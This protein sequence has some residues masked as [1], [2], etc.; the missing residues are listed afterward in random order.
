[1]GRASFFCMPG[2]GHVNPTLPL[3]SELVKRGERIDYWT[4]PDFR[5]GIENAGATFCPLPRVFDRMETLDKNGGVFAIGEF[6]A[7]ATLA[8]LPE[9]TA[10]LEKDRPDYVLSD[11]MSVF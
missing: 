10:A 8:S 7:E 6:M 2:H 4:G 1:M 3:V 11:S 5:P 9:L